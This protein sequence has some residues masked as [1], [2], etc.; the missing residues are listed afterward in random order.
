MKYLTPED[1]VTLEIILREYRVGPGIP[2][3][4]DVTYMDR[5]I[6]RVHFTTR[7]YRELHRDGE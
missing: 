1:L 7:L 3:L 5:Y 2:D 4:N 6:S